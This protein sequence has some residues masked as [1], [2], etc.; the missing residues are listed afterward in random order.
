MLIIAPQ[1]LQ[2]VG[3][4]RKNNEVTLKASGYIPN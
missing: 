4:S 1:C 3:I 2:L